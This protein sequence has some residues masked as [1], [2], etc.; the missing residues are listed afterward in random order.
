LRLNIHIVHKL[1]KLSLKELIM[2]L[3]NQNTYTKDNIPSAKV[4]TDLIKE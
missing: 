4:L 3:D 2:P 1:F